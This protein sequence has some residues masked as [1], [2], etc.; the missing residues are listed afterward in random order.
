MTVTLFGNT[1]FE[2]VS[3]LSC[4]GLTWALNLMPWIQWSVLV[5][6]E[7]FEGVMTHEVKKAM[8]WWTERLQRLCC[9]SS[10]PSLLGNHWEN[11]KHFQA[12]QEGT[13]I[14]ARLQFLQGSIDIWLFLG[15]CMSFRFPTY[16]KAWWP[17]FVFW[18]LKA[19]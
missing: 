5:R 15:P 17:I 8:W 19:C 10:T 13:R 16:G 9:K 4:T 6:T 1:V 3:N 2:D 18:A 14:K 7:R 12:N 11:N